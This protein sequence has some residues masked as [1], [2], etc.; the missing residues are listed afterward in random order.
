MLY[1]Y[2]KLTRSFCQSTLKF[3]LVTGS[4]NL[5]FERPSFKSPDSNGEAA[6]GAIDWAIENHLCVLTYSH[7]AIKGK[8]R[9][10]LDA[11]LDHAHKAGIVTTFIHTGHPGNILPLG[12]WSGADTDVNLT[13]MF[14]NT[15]IRL[16][17]LAGKKIKLL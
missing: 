6:A 1:G 15:T 12:L 4:R 2:G 17:E 11:A 14:Y 3:L 5:Y 9:K 10:I 7:A 8:Q 16:L 13:S